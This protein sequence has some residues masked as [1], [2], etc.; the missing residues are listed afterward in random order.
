MTKSKNKKK[1]S[2]MVLR[3]EKHEKDQF[4]DICK[5]QDTSAAREMR[6]FM[7]AFVAAN[8]PAPPADPTEPATPQAAPVVAE[9][10]EVVNIGPAPKAP[11]AR[12]KPDRT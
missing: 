7:R 11:R 12:K 10:V 4:L 5:A 1:S 2:Q 9:P 6:R 8:Q 3:V